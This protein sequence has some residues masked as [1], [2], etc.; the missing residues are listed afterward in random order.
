MRWY[1]GTQ[2]MSSNCKGVDKV[3]AR[4]QVEWVLL[5]WGCQG[6]TYLMIF[7]IMLLVVGGRELRGTR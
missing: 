2:V 7:V 3:K 6:G 5:R 1:E 4:E